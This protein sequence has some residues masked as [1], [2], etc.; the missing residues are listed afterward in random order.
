MNVA[1]AFDRKKAGPLWLLSILQ[2]PGHSDRPFA[3]CREK[4]VFG[5][6][7]RTI[8]ADESGQEW[9]QSHQRPGQGPTFGDCS[10][11]NPSA[12]GDDTY[13]D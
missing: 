5:A 7:N 2:E 1:S 10:G 11:G 8:E 3:L 9:K 12:E 13:R 6:L 4:L